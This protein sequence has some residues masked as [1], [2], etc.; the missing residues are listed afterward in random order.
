MSEKPSL[1]RVYYAIGQT[2]DWW[3]TLEHLVHDLCLHL[4]QCLSPDFAK[5]ATNAPLHIALTNMGIRER[6]ATAK[7][8]ASQAPTAEPGFYSRLESLLNRLDNELRSERNRY[9]HDLW[10]L[11]DAGNGIERIQQR[12]IVTRPQS[13][14]I[15]LEI[16]TI[17][18]FDSIENVEAFV[19]DLEKMHHSLVEIDG[20]VSGMAE[21]LARLELLKLSI[22]LG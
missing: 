1:D 7:A 10:M 15:S 18:A 19:S 14:Q 13:H 2:C 16:D 22:V 4:A 12:T 3:S 21:R 11:S 8:F 20:E 5:S 17:K 6:I 9:V